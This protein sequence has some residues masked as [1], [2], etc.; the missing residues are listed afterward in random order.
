[1]DW[2]ELS[3]SVKLDWVSGEVDLSVSVESRTSGGRLLHLACSDQSVGP[4]FGSTTPHRSRMSSRHCLGIIRSSA[5]P[6]FLFSCMLR[7]G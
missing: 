4:G 7:A 6:L 1:M 2:V 5:M 3:W